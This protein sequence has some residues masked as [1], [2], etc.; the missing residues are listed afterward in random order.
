MK[1][2]PFPARL[3]IRDLL[4]PPP[5]VPGSSRFRL[6][7]SDQDDSER[8]AVSV[9]AHM[10]FGAQL[11]AGGR[12][13]PD[14][15]T[16][17]P[18]G[19]DEASTPARN[20][21]IS[22]RR[23]SGGPGR[24]ISSHRPASRPG[25]RPARAGPTGASAHLEWQ[26]LPRGSRCTGQTGCRSAPHGSPRVADRPSSAVHRQEIAGRSPLKREWAKASW[27]CPPLDQIWLTKRSVRHSKAMAAADA[28]APAAPAAAPRLGKPSQTAAARGAS[29]ASSAICPYGAG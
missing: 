29:R 6:V 7:G 20:P 9:D 21:S 23:G 8:Q 14:R 17:V 18:A 16:P 4:W 10:P 11:A 12:V 3:C 24:W 5:A 26:S 13:R 2:R 22:P 28:M 15:V 25:A 19:A 1:P 27:P